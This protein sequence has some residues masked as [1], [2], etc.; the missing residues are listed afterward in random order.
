[1]KLFFIAAIWLAVAAC[2]KPGSALPQGD[3]AGTFVRAQPGQSAPV[4]NVTLQISGNHFTGSS[5]MVKYP[6]ICAGTLSSK[7]STM[8]VANS[9]VFTAE[10]DWSFIFSGDYNYTFDGNN[11]KIWRD[12][13]GQYTDRY[14]LSRK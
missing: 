8:E 10:F 2:T 5:N 1:M 3:F 9:C 7:G 14:D 13:G 12:Y 4:A 6:A 11:L